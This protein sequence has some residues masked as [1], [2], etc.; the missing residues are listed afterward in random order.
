MLVIQAVVVALLVAHVIQFVGTFIYH[1]FANITEEGGGR[2][3]DFLEWRTVHQCDF[4][5]FTL[6]GALALFNVFVD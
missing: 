5:V 2:R 6:V 1:H 4:E 3:K